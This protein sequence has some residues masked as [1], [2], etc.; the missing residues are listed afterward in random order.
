M[1]FIFLD[2]FVMVVDAG[3][4]VIQIRQ[5]TIIQYWYKL[6]K[7]YLILK[8]KKDSFMSSS[9]YRIRLMCVLFLAQQL[10]KE[11]KTTSNFWSA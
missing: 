1:M 3:D 2:H 6:A 10:Q 7:Q 4:F 9:I 5:V 11:K 8:N